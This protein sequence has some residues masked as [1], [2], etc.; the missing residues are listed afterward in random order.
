MIYVYAPM[1][2]KYF[3]CFYYTRFDIMASVP[4]SNGMNESD[5]DAKN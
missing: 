3:I 1:S 4:P 5:F 2:R